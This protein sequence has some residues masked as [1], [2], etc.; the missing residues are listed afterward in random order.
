MI[1][2]DPNPVKRAVTK[3][4]WHPEST[5]DLR[6]GVAYAMLRF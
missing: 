4:C 2:K 5:T 3:I 1:F 6:V